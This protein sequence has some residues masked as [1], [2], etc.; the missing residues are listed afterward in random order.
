MAELITAETLE[1]ILDEF[2]VA[3]RARITKEDA[4]PTVRAW[5]DGLTGLTAESVHTAAKRHMQTVKLFP[6][7]S[8]IRELALEFVG[9]TNGTMPAPRAN[10]LACPICGAEPVPIMAIRPRRTGAGEIIRDAAGEPVMQE[11]EIRTEVYHD[12]A[13]HHIQEGYAP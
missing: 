2:R 1:P 7:I 4:A 10:P 13:A 12:R 6:R 8:E 3:Y 5:L 9:R 11:I